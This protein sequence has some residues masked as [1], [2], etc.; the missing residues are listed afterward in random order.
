VR[1]I[2]PNPTGI[3]QYTKGGGNRR[4][5]SFGHSG[6]LK[7]TNALR[8][9]NEFRTAVASARKVGKLGKFLKPRIDP[10]G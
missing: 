7:G 9:G 4:K 1:Q 2:V 5:V 8:R 6:L 3:N 10:I